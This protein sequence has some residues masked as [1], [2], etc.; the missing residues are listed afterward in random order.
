MRPT[1]TT[2]YLYKTK[3]NKAILD[4]YNANQ[5]MQSEPYI[6]TI[7]Y[8]IILPSLC[9]RDSP[10]WGL[11]GLVDSNGNFIE[12]SKSETAFGGY[13]DYSNIDLIYIDEEVIYIPIVPKHWGHFLLNTLSR[14]W[15]IDLIN[16]S[17]KIAFCIW[18]FENDITGEID[19]ILK[20]FNITN[21]RRIVVKTPTKFKKILLPSESFGYAANYSYEY[22]NVFRFIKNRI[23][24]LE[25]FKNKP[26]YEKIYLTRRKFL[27][28]RYNEFGEKEIEKVFEKN[29]F[30]VLAPEDLNVLEQ[31]YY[32]SK[33]D[34]LACASGTSPHNAM[35]MKKGSELIVLNRTPDIN[36]PQI[37]I[38]KLFNIKT[39][40]I[41]CYS[42]FDNL[43]P[44]VYGIGP[45]WF[46]QNKLFRLFLK[47]HHFDKKY[48]IISLFFVN[49]LNFCKYIAAKIF[50]PIYRMIKNMKG[51]K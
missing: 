7:D 33:C 44:P 31:V 8:G 4:Y 34:V 48:S 36:P 5:E 18:G 42:V 43:K 20:L 23:F 50:I 3:W 26:Y 47:E 39:T 37:K 17:F 6:L 45:F 11:G 38:E 32:I 9:T 22:T 19:L 30:Q 12:E 40:H 41:D 25:E 46:Y 27:K 28:H 35:F 51:K 1:M 10:N 13:Y 49:C 16:S 29:G 15:K 2:K 21:E 14:F 24:E